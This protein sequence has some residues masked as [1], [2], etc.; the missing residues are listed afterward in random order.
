MSK[1][2]FLAIG[3]MAPL[4]LVHTGSALSSLTLVASNAVTNHASFT[5]SGSGI[6]DY[7][8]TSATDAY[9]FYRCQVGSLKSCKAVGYVDQALPA[10]QSMIANPLNRTDNRLNVVLPDM[11]NGSYLHK[12]DDASAQ[13]CEPNVFLSG[14]GWLDTNMTLAPGEGAIIDMPSAMTNSFVGEYLQG[15]LTNPVPAGWSI[16][17]SKAP[18]AGPVASGLR[19]PVAEGDLVIQM[20]SG[21]YQTFAYRNGRWINEAG[22]EVAEPVIGVAESFWIIKP[23][24]WEQIFSVW[25]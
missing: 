13:Y 5:L 16:R 19:A 15:Y 8:D 22:S 2:V 14:S 12:F 20:I 23:T 24:D 11:P 25:P 9:R 6:Y 17:A 4:L 21:T 7:T 18:V 10:G 3:C 1:A